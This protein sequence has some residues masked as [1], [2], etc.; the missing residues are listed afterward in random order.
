MTKAPF[1]TWKTGLSSFVMPPYGW[2]G[3]LSPGDAVARGCPCAGESPGNWEHKGSFL[4]LRHPAPP[5]MQHGRDGP[6][7][8]YVCCLRGGPS[9]FDGRVPSGTGCPLPREIQVSAQWPRYRS[10]AT[11][12]E[13]HNA[14]TFPGHMKPQEAG[15]LSLPRPSRIGWA[16]R[17]RWRVEG[18]VL[19]PD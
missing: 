1:S 19:R 15:I 11:K 17:V 7:L 10:V 5:K 2:P 16:T 18:S 13:A 9:V 6:S 12:L 14:P 4:W 3:L 8:R